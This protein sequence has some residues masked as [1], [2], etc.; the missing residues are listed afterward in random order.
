MKNGRNGLSD[1]IPLNLKRQKLDDECIVSQWISDLDV[2]LNV[3]PFPELETS[4]ERISNTTEVLYL[5]LDA[6]IKRH[7]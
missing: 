4:E 2:F 3:A 6:C 1:G 5:V 7:G